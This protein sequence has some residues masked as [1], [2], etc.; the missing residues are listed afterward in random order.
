MADE[1]VQPPQ[2]SVKFK[3]E[4]GCDHTPEFQTSYELIFKSNLLFT[5]DSGLGHSF[6]SSL[7]G[8]EEA[9]NNVVPDSAERTTQVMQVANN[10]GNR[11][12]VKLENSF[13]KDFKSMN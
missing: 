11:R 4:V 5:D 2:E 12:M 1:N 13:G 3:F 8:A 9:H 6:P 10:M 7:N